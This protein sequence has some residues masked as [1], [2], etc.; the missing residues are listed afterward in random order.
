H[1]L[2]EAV[3]Q[4]ADHGG[5]Q[6]REQDA[7]HEAP[8]D[9]VVEEAERE[10]HQAPEV[11]RQERQDRAEL[12]QD[13]ERIAE[14]LVAEAEEMPHQQQVAG[15][16]N[17]EIFG[18]PLDEAEDD[19]LDD[20]FHGIAAPGAPGGKDSVDSRLTLLLWPR[21]GSRAMVNR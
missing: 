4:R 18:Q 13:S 16:R 14:A 7:E 17:R 1:A 21:Q 9:R 15:R 20:V 19:R 3:Q 10:L 12:D 5:G 2:D 11:D 8:R 6:E